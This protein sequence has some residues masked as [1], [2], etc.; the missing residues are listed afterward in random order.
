MIN[1]LTK[2]SENMNIPFNQ[3]WN[4]IALQSANDH[5]KFYSLHAANVIIGEID[6]QMI[7]DLTKKKSYDTE[8]LPSLF[9]YREILWQPN[10]FKKP[11]FCMPS[12]RIFKAFCEEKAEEYDQE[13][14][15]KNKIYS[16]L[17]QGLA[18]NCGHALKDLEKKRQ[19]VYIHKVLKEL[20]KQSFP[21]VKFFIDHP[22]NRND[23]YHEAIN[24]LNYAIK[25]SIT[26]FNSRFTE[27]EDPFWK[28][29]GEPKTPKNETRRTQKKSVTKEDPLREEKAIF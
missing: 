10:V 15:K 2:F 9:T 21:I 14:E 20:R 29:E 4:F 12:I 18:E 19:P 16:G 22:Q 24:R 23:Y 26:E 5:K 7:T 13:K 1:I 3:I 17:L 28:V 6:V 11:K 27:F 8:L 25:I